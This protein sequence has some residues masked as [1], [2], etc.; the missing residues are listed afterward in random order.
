MIHLHQSINL[1]SMKKIY[2]DYTVKY[3]EA[4][5]I[6]IDRQITACFENLKNENQ[7]I[8]VGSLKNFANTFKNLMYIIHDFDF[9]HKKYKF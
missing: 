1:K 9:I 8:L 4:N 2:F 7:N 6:A 3:S 5:Y